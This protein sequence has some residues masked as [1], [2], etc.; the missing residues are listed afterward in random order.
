[1][2]EQT[3]YIDSYEARPKQNNSNSRLS[4]LGIGMMLGGLILGGWL[5]V[6]LAIFGGASLFGNG[7]TGDDDGEMERIRK[8]VTKQI[9]EFTLASLEAPYTR[10]TS[11]MLTH[12][13]KVLQTALKGLLAQV[14]AIAHSHHE[15]L[16]TQIADIERQRTGAEAPRE[17]SRLQGILA[18][19]EELSGRMKG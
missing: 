12:L 4:G 2:R 3:E 9:R 1:V 10:L 16:R 18:K 14:E 6:G 15:K 8:P 13:D 5:G 7:S 19:I 17:V 11:E